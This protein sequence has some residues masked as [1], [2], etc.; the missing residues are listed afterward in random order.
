MPNDF[1]V[2]L[3]QAYIAQPA[4][5]IGYSTSKGG[6]GTVRA[7]VIEQPILIAQATSSTKKRPGWDLKSSRIQSNVGF[8]KSFIRIVIKKAHD[9]VGFLSKG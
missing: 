9:S 4:I 7:M 6:V 2:K 5:Q 8:N 3:A 1:L